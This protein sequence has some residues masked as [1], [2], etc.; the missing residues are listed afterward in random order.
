MAALEGRRGGGG[1]GPRGGG[2]AFPP[3]AA[4]AA[5]VVVP[6]AAGGPTDVISRIVTGHMAQTLGQSIIIDNK[7]GAAGGIGTGRQIAAALALGAQL[8]ARARERV[9]VDRWFGFVAPSGQP[10]IRAAK[11]SARKNSTATVGAHKP[12]TTFAANGTGRS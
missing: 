4:G 8:V 5:A 7:G 3:I 9:E 11:R 12:P 10:F 2:G 6:F 1:E